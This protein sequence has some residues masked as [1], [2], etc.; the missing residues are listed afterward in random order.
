MNTDRSDGTT[1]LGLP[2]FVVLTTSES[3]GQLWLLVETTATDAQV[4]GLRSGYHGMADSAPTNASKWYVL[5][6]RA[7]SD[8]HIDPHETTTLLAF[9][10]SSFTAR[11][12]MSTMKGGERILTHDFRCSIGRIFARILP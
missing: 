9:S 6:L 4:R 5:S 1:L 2:G 10:G 11:I 7:T 3:D 8:G 12:A